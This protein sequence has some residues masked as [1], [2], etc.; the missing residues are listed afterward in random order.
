M[1]IK[2]FCDHSPGLVNLMHARQ[3]PLDGVE[4]TPFSSPKQIEALR[5]DYP[6]LPFQFHASNVGRVPFFLRKLARYN[7][8][9]SESAW[10]SIHLSLVPSLILFCAFR[11]GVG[12]PM[13]APRHLESRF[14]RQVRRLA[15]RISL[16]LILENMPATPLLN[17][18]FESAPA[19]IRRV[20][21]VL[22][23]GL[24]LDLAHAQVAAAFQK[25]SIENY[26]LGL[27]LERVREIHISGVREIDGVLRD[28]HESLRETD[29]ELLA[30]VLR[31]TKPE[32]VTLEYFR[33][34]L[35]A[36]KEML[37][38]LHQC[39]EVYSSTE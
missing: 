11:L 16:P 8:V 33:D 9:C 39:R 24:L 20:L 36:L 37:N 23:T 30:W 28:A 5:A 38:R 4:F 1:T 6:G 15:A 26:L 12:L 25:M 27:P 13:A 3:V 18:G 22:N 31:R 32:M 10:V 2:L 19:T 14:I 17:N 34:D 29:Y 35:A 7:Q 21:S